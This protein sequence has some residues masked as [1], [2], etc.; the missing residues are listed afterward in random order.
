MFHVKHQ[1]RRLAAG[2][3]TALDVFLSQHADSSMHL[4]ANLRRAGFYDR[5]EPYQGVYIAALAGDAIVGVVAH[6]WNGMVVVQAP[7]DVEALTVEA[8]AT[9]GRKIVGLLGP[10]DQVTRAQSALGLVRGEATEDSTD[11]LFALDLATLQIP[12]ALAEGRIVVRHPVATEL[13]LV[14][15]WSVAFNCEALGFGESAE[16]RRNCAELI[17]RLQVE[18]AHF[19]LQEAGT[20]VAYAA[21]NAMLPDM[22]QL[23][24]VWT[25]PPL[26]GR[27]YARNVVAGA[28]LAARATGV[29]R[30]TLFTENDNYAAQSAYRSLGFSKIGV[31]GIVIFP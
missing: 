25:P 5:N 8:A 3:E 15:E 22:V 23:G 13:A 29:K 19:V 17:G 9:S 10:G 6:F 14:T 18:R 31:Y 24:G 28:L 12:A 2:D 7:R 11:D 16:L 30:A 26:R 21:F 1:I 27:G 4:R 20:A